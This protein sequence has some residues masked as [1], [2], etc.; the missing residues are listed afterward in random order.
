MRSSFVLVAAAA[1]LVAVGCGGDDSG[2]GGGGT[3]TGTGTGT[4]S[5][6]GTGAGMGGSGGS[7]TG[8][9]GF[10]DICNDAYNDAC[11]DCTQANCCTELEAC[12]M[13]ADCQQLL[14]CFLEGTAPA[15]CIGQV[16]QS[17][18]VLDLTGCAVAECGPECT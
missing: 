13:D 4:G 11:I 16:N 7:A 6:T 1:V 9:G 14:N 18:A 3:G 5:G 12:T 17:D 2:T 10:G 15:T 8:M